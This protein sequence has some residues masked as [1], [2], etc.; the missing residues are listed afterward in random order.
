MNDKISSLIAAQRAGYA[1]AQPFYTSDTV[2]EAD[3]KLVFGQ[4]WWL[5]GHSSQIPNAGDYLLFDILTDSIIIVRDAQ[6]TI[7]AFANVCRHRGSRLCTDLQGNTRRITCPYHAWTYNLDGSLFSA[8][9]L[10]ESHDRSDLSLHPIRIEVLAGLIYVSLSNDPPDFAPLRRRMEPVLAPFGLDRTRIAHRAIYPVQANW[11]LLV[12]NYNECYH[13]TSTHPEF[14]RSHAIHM[15]ENRVAPLNDAMRARSEECGVPVDYID[16][17]GSENRTGG[18]DHSYNRYALLDGFQT[19]SEGG[20]PLAPLLGSLTG[21][22]GG[23]S[24]AYVGLLNPM[25][26]YCDHAV[27]YRFHPISKE[28]SLQEIIW[29][30]HEDAVEG[31]DYD[32][33]RLIWL[34]DVTTHADKRIVEDNARGVAAQHYVPG[35]LVSMERFIQRFI[36]AYQTM[37]GREGEKP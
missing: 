25:L 6:G 17:I 18:C 23:A 11:K 16:Q 21:Y 7:R 32:L 31:E 24:D 5:A 27:L 15:P 22:D 12:E 20:Q 10:D 35:P 8:R 33:D 28:A 4:E 29:L 3:R 19:G 14:S 37:L 1:M 26:I 36:E 2:F 34:W 30:V 13:C 9:L